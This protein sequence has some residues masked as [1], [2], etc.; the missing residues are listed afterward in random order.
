MKFAIFLLM[1]PLAATAATPVTV[2]PFSDLAITA[3]QRAPATVEALN[4]P[5]LAAEISARLEEL[6]V[7]VG[8]KVTL[9]GL[10]AR[11]D[12]RLYRSQANAARAQLE[13]LDARRRFAASQLK[14]ARNLKA[15]RS[16]SEETLDQRRSEL[17]S[18]TALSAVQ[19]QAIVQADIQVNRCEVRAP[20]PAVVTA[21]LADV[22]SLAIPGTPLVKLTQLDTLE[23]SAHLRQSEVVDLER[24]MA[25]WFAYQGVRYP[26]RLRTTVAVVDEHKRTREARLTFVAATAPVGAS[27]RLIWQ[28]TQTRL[29]AELLVRRDD[30][31]G[32]FQVNDGKAHFTPLSGAREGEPAPAALTPNTLVVIEGRQR[33]VDEDDVEIVARSN[34]E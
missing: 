13:E 22:G 12:C 34:D 7:L 3:E 20:F 28:D 9:G 5:E 23:I 18:L 24:T 14:R 15:N 25:V 30:Q 33:I 11:L 29:P 6:P 21:R 10:V 19:E 26:V 32:I 8:T 4:A 27:G 17:N 31:L 16:V 2:K 1:L